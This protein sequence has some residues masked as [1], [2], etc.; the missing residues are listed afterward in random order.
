MAIKY[1]LDE[2]IS[3][4]IK[5]I[6]EEYNGGEIFFGCMFLENGNIEDI[7]PICY[8]NDEA[9][10]APYEIVQKFNAILH[11]HPSGNIKPSSADLD[12]ASYLQQ[13]G[14]GF[15]IIDNEG[16]NLNTVVPPIINKKKI[17]LDIEPIKKYF[18][19]GGKINNLKNDYEFR[20]GQL[21]M[22]CKVAE[23]FN[24][25][26]IAII[27]AGTGI[28]KSLAY[29]IPA[30]LWVEKNQERIV[31]STNTINLQS[32]L[33]NNDIPIVKKIL[34]SKIEA[35]VVKGRRNYLCKLKLYNFKNELEFDEET[36]ELNSILKWSATTKNGVIDELNFVPSNSTW[37]K[38]SSDVDFCI[39]RHCV[40]FQDCFFQAVKR[41]ASESNILI[42]NHHILFADISIRSQG[43]GLDE[44]S[45]L[46][47]YRKIIFDE[48]HNIE[49]SASSFFSISFL[50]NGFYK[51][52]S[53]IRSKNDKG[54]LPRLLKRLQNEGSRELSD[55]ADFISNEVLNVFSF[56]FY[57]SFDIFN[58]IN[59][60]LHR[61]IENKNYNN[62]Y[63]INI[64]YRIKKD[65]WE[66]EEFKNDLIHQLKDLALK[67][68]EL[69][70]SFNM[71][72]VKFDKCPAKLKAKYE[73]DIK[74]LK[75]YQNKLI[76]IQ[77]N[78]VNLLN[79][80]VDEY[81][82]WIEIFGEQN[83]LSFR[84][85]ATPLHI[86]KL[87]CQHVYEIFDSIIFS[88]ATLTVNKTFDF[89]K[90]TTGLS[91]VKNKQIIEDSIDSPFNYKKNVL[92][93]A[94][95]DIPEPNN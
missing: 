73:I 1:S 91:I 55:I 92:F 74:L 37:D 10:L 83:N 69:E 21:Q 66:S 93:V 71:L 42:V 38:V 88:S 67:I 7:E 53:Y 20:E 28:G 3:N 32:Q 82:T 31:I 22:A 29:L 45:L 16:L 72:S 35:M 18:S 63:K 33:L 17:K 15:F 84:L 30:F 94:P 36:E 11:N 12:Y 5:T 68:E 87:L 54:F 50:K 26:K 65:E 95:V 70:K 61:I 59:P 9:V 90:I 86:E 49:K 56:L 48:A 41:K 34:N 24:E 64:Q 47:P 78:L 13:E 27:E 43:K 57:S 23:S 6:I 75:S 52:L 81:V 51:F 25:D 76:S 62:N 79:I 19:P 77:E 14:I 89:F 2:K 60:Y 39:R 85:S 46:P 58:N 44:N 4:K 40:F 80:K 8:G